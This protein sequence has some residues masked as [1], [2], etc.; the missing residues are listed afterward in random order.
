M[1]IQTAVGWI[2]DVSKDNDSNNIIIHIK[3]QGGKIIRF[4][5]SLHEHIFYVLPKSY[6]D[7]QDLIQ[8]LSR[9]DQVIK[10]IFWDEKFIDIQDKTRTRLIGIGL[11]TNRQDFKKLV[12][13]LE[14]DSRVKT[15]YNI[16]LSEVMQFICMQ[17][18]IPPTSKVEI[19]YDNVAERL[20]SI[21][22]IDD[23]R[24]L[25]LPHSR[26]CISKF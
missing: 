10:R 17:L 24:E 2:L 22:K 13:T 18:R 21:S 23:S 26:L 20:L 9:H 5:Q 15:L 6:S 12:Q 11:S 25:S 19:E 14:H 7:G 8:Q 4:K 16:D 1:A 3:L